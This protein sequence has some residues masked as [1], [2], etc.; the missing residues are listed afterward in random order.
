MNKNKRLQYFLIALVVL[1][2]GTFIFKIKHFKKEDN[3]SF[4]TD[5]KPI[6]LIAD[7]A[8]LNS[9]KFEISLDYPDPFLR[10][11]RPESTKKKHTNNKPFKRVQQKESLMPEIL[12]KGYFL[13]KNKVVK[14][15]ID[16]KK[17]SHTLSKNETIGGLVLKKMQK[18]H[19]LVSWN[20]KTVP[21]YR[22]K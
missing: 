20:G 16:F 8:D 18:D 14:V 5:F 13:E 2:W 21:I 9:T 7:S 4:N 19:I 11:D 22:Q 1:I 6:N 12:Y 17:E 3:L 10:N 15:N